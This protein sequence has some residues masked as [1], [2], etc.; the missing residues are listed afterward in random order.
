MAE[1]FTPNNAGTGTSIIY[2]YGGSQAYSGSAQWSVTGYE[3]CPVVFVAINVEMHTIS[4]II[5]SGYSFASEVAATPNPSSISKYG[6][7]ILFRNGTGVI[8]ISL[9]RSPSGALNV[10]SWLVIGLI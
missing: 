3:N 9:Y 4:N 6:A 1:C 10:R 7:T 8:N 5:P 2:T